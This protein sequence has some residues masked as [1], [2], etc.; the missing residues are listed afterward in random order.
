LRLL[1]S[2]VTRHDGMVR[3]YKRSEAIS[4]LVKLCA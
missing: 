3:H 4:N 1:R 2:F